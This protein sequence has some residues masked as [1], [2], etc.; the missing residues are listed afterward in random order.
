[1]LAGDLIR[2]LKARHPED[3]VVVE[4]P[5]AQGSR[6]IDFWAMRKSWARSRIDAYEVKISRADWLRDQKILE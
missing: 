6:Y 4:A 5:M 2:L 3:L 1:M